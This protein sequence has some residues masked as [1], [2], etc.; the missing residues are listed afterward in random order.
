[1]EKYAVRK[2]Y[3]VVINVVCAT[4]RRTEWVT[5]ERWPHDWPR[6]KDVVDAGHE[7]VDIGGRRPEFVGPRRWWWW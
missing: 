5:G 2:Q 6:V 4:G 3:L 7:T 1:M